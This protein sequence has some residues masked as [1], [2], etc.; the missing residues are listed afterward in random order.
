MHIFS[1]IY[2]CDHIHLSLCKL[3]VLHVISYFNHLSKHGLVNFSHTKN[4]F[5]NKHES[6]VQEIKNGSF[7]IRFLG[8]HDI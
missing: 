8:T 2:L 6:L 4:M 7:A 3:C 5:L 1:N